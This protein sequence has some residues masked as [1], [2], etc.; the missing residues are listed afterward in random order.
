MSTPPSFPQGPSISI[1]VL[2]TIFNIIPEHPALQFQ[3]FKSILSISQENNLYDYVSPYFK[4]V[5]QWLKEWNVSAQEQSQI[6]AIIISMAEKAEDR[7][8]AGIPIAYSSE[9]YNLLLSALSVASPSEANGLVMKAIRAAIS[10][11]QVFDFQQLVSLP[12][13]QQFQKDK[14]PAYDFLQIFLTGN[15]ESYRTFIK[16][17]PSWLA[18]NR[19]PFQCAELTI[20]MDASKAE[21]KIRLLTLATLSNTPT[22]TL[23]Y[24]KIASSLDIPNDD[25]ELWLIDIIRA[26]LVEGKLSQARQ[27]LLVHRSTYRTFGK[28][29]W[30]ELDSRLEDWKVALEQVLASEQIAVLREQEQ[31]TTT[32]VNGTSAGHEVAT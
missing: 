16:S 30:E 25:V 18:D 4:S 2:S 9:L 14:N 20:D 32:A 23:P 3:V 17:H 29:E 15:L 19:S 27:E 7:Y 22:R 10:L 26:G 13:V 5:N 21:R 6:W 24:S 8:Q 1:A 11:P 31:P 12:S 28:E